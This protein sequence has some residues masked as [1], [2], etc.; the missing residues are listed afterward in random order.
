FRLRDNNSVIPGSIDGGGGFDTL[1]YS[2][3]PAPFG[4][5]VNLAMGTAAEV[6]GGVRNVSNV[7]G[8]PNAD[9]ITGNPGNN[10]LDGGA[11]NDIISGGG[12]RDILIGG[13]GADTI[14]GGVGDD[15]LIGGDLTFAGTATLSP[16]DAALSA[17]MAEWGRTDA[18]AATRRAHL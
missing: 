5:V 4:V 9:S 3:W 2:S 14:S 10:V 18:V 8:T 17:L 15:I 1:D 7:L 16:N 13:Q 6:F 11:G 12:G